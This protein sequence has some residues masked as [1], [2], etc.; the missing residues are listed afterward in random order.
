MLY[1][2]RSVQRKTPKNI[3]IESATPTNRAN[4]STEG[5]ISRHRAIAS[6]RVQSLGRKKRKVFTINTYATRGELE[7]LQHV[8]QQN[9]WEE[10]TL[11]NE[12]HLIWFG[13][14]LRE[15]DIK[16]VQRRPD[17]FFNK[18]SGTEYLCRK[19][20]LCSITNRMKRYFPDQ[21][22]FVPKE[23]LYPEERHELNEFCKENPNTWMIAKPS[24]GC[25]GEGIFLFKGKFNCPLLNN[26][27]VIQQYISKPLL[28]E[29]KKFDLRIYCL[30]KSFEPLEAYFCNEGMVR[31]CTEDYCEP[32]EENIDQLF[33]HLTNFSL[34]KDNDKYI[35]TTEYGENN[36][37]TKR[38]LSHFFAQLVRE[39]GIDEN[40]VKEQIIS[41]IK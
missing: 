31:F 21:F 29:N 20:V 24:R 2:D 11:P 36:K 23:F 18:Y 15:S 38:L 39:E 10:S 9:N 12:G 1:L 17:V 37:G 33:M 4:F 6:Q 41:T 14:P 32:T 34:N 22:S 16:L 3:K 26:E 27:F 28:I 35:N 30:I 8:I 5:Y 40:Y 13:L 25:G 19:K 7:T